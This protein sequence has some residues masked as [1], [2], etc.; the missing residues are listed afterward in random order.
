MKQKRAWKLVNVGK[1]VKIGDFP[2]TFY[3]PNIFFQGKL[4]PALN[5]ANMYN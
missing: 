2:S 5:A 3:L 4:V 1:I